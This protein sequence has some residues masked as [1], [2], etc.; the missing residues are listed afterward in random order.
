MSTYDSALVGPK[1]SGRPVRRD[2]GRRR[3]PVRRFLTIALLVFFAFLMLMPFIWLISS[4]L[5]SQIQI[6]QYPPQWIPNPILFKNYVDALTYKPFLLYFRNSLIIAALNVTAVGF[7]SSFCSYCFAPIPFLGGNFLFWVVVS[8]L[9][10]PS[11]LALF[12][13]VIIF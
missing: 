2:S 10:F 7:T 1:V 9:F 5:K 13:P 6:F 12:P 11:L 3:N 4:S 8:T